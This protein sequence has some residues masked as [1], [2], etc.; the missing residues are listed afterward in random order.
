MISA[1][2]HA[3]V[4]IK[5]FC[6]AKSRLT[7]LLTPHER[8]LLAR[9]MLQDVLER[10]VAAPSL[11]G[12]TVLTSDAEAMAMARDYGVNVRDDAA[13]PDLNAALAAACA[14]IADNGNAGVLIVPGDVPLLTTTDIT[15]AVTMLHAH[16]IV[17]APA[18]RDGGTNLLGCLPAQSIAPCFGPDSFRRHRG[19]ARRAGITPHLMLRHTLAL[20]IDL[21]VDIA[22]LLD[23]P[24]VTRSATL[25]EDLGI[26]AR[27]RAMTYDADIHTHPIHAMAP[28]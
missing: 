15:D 18:S 7:P 13:H 10:L 9:T 12:V 20:D 4:P 26:A 2:I 22:A 27:L 23:T 5:P 6:L 1:A 17:L 14:A 25:L 19:A 28:G 16:H 24:A 8:A 21:P 11:A 3:L